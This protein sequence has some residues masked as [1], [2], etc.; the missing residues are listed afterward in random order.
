MTKT[1]YLKVGAWLLAI[2]LGLIQ[3]DAYRFTLSSDDP[4]SYLDIGDAYLRGDWNAALNSYWSPLYSWIVGLA[5]T[6]LKPSMY[7]EFPV[8]KLVNF[9]I[10]LF[11]LASFEFFLTQLVRYY[12]RKL[13][14]QDPNA[15]FSV[16]GWVWVALGY[17]LFVW[18]SLNWTTLRSDTPDL[19]TAALVYIAAGML[20]RLYTAAYS[21]LHF[22]LLGTVLGFAY[23]AKAV[24]FPVSFAF[25]AVALFSAGTW[26]RGLPRT[27]VALLAFAIVSLPFVF[28]LS[29]AKGRITFGDVGPINYVLFVNPNRNLINDHHWQGENPKFGTPKHPVRK[30]FDAPPAY[31]FATPV[32]GTYPP[33]YDPS[34]WLD[35]LVLRFSLDRQIRASATN[36]Q[37][38]ND[39][40][41]GKLIFGYFVLL[42]AAGVLKPSL[43]ELIASW[44]LL[45]PAAAGLGIYCIGTTLFSLPWQPPT[46]YVAPFIVLAFAGAFSSLRLADSQASRRLVVGMTI[47]TL[48]VVGSQLAFNAVQESSMRRTAPHLHWEIAEGLKQLNVQSGQKVAILGLDLGGIGWARLAR[49]QIIAEI[50]N[51]DTFWSSDVAAR[52]EVLKRVQKTG[53]KAIVKEPGT[54]TPDSAIA[55]GWRQI[56]N[57]GSYVYFFEDK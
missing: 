47:A 9:T 53:A 14:E 17:T 13:S 45:V 20:L 42:F 10:Y 7:W 44:R 40:F 15:F 2:V 29:T 43:K 19:L 52:K 8:L 18:S 35:G 25:L 3:V 46:R 50:P 6:L 39:V 30:I 1:T 21:W 24:M 27:L 41:L 5:M 55:E 36:I 56:G 34:Y 38:Y 37:F 11:A 33:W 12:E 31:E 57:T 16:P 22:T 4:I 26:R 48:F 51:V 32:P 28:A 54:R 49:L 23:L